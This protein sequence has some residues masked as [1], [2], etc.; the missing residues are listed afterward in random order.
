MKSSFYFAIVLLIVMMSF[1]VTSYDSYSYGS[2]S[3][4]TSTS[5]YLSTSTS[6]TTSS[7]PIS[8]NYAKVEQEVL[9]KLKQKIFVSVI[10]H[11]KDNGIL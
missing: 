6:L 1:V 5:S 3:G 8:Y 9:D 10:V 4:T 2:Y 11:M 7:T